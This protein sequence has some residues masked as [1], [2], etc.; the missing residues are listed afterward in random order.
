[1]DVQKNGRLQKIATR[2]G[3]ATGWTRWTCAVCAPKSSLVASTATLG[4]WRWRFSVWS[5]KLTLHD[6]AL[7]FPGREPLFS[8]LHF[9]VG[10]GEFIVIRGTSGCGKSTLLRLMNRLQEPDA[11]HL[12]VDGVDACSL[13]P[14]AL[15][16]KVG[17]LQQTAVMVAGTVRDNLLVPFRY[18]VAVGE[19]VPNDHVLRQ[20]MAAFGLADLALDHNASRLSVGQKQRIGLLRAL[21]SVPEVLLCDEPTAALD[22]VSRDI[23]H[24]RLVAYVKEGRAVVLVT[25]ADFSCPSLEMRRL[26][27]AEGMLV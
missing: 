6:I 15:R 12:T 11:G 20:E 13:T 19:P 16:R 3:L 2:C 18:A 5:M 27:L 23:V 21:L 25:H 14:M 17:Y 7:T 1:M 10:P 26:T 24:E 4:L 22:P 8:G 9:A